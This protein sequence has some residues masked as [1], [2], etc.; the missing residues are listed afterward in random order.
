MTR[1]FASPVG[2]GNEHVYEHV[3]IRSSCA[4]DR[5]LLKVLQSIVWD[6]QVIYAGGLITK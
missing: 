4:V 1:H 6:K 5:M 3:G 2:G